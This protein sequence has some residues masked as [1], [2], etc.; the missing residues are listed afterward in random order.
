M[1]RGKVLALSYDEAGGVGEIVLVC[2]VCTFARIVG[3]EVRWK[4]GTR[5]KVMVRTSLLT[6]SRNIGNNVS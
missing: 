4:E 3:L 1:T 5:S 6:S 2:E